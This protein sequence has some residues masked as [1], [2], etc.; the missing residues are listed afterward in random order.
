MVKLYTLT[1]SS[2]NGWNVQPKWHRQMA[3]YR[4][5]TPKSIWEQAK[6]NSS[7]KLAL[8]QDSGGAQNKRQVLREFNVSVR[9]QMTRIDP[10]EKDIFDSG[11]AILVLSDNAR[12]HHC[13][14]RSARMLG[15]Q[16]NCLTGQHVAVVLPE[17]AEIALMSKEQANPQLRLWARTGH[18][19]DGFGQYGNPFKCEI[20][21]NHK[22]H[23]G[24]HYMQL[25]IHTIE[26]STD[27]LQ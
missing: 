18:R 20:F 11:L 15:W 9:E 24:H 3:A 27:S 7:A 10:I 13:N 19:F 2:G 17:L 6:W 16:T 21:F 23:L 8:E 22:E 26:K 5:E 14:S 4:L 25:I 12:I 1:N